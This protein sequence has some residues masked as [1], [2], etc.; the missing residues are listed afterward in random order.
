MWVS[1]I[2]FGYLRFGEGSGPSLWAPA[3]RMA[4]V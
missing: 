2:G 1:V 4:V 3:G